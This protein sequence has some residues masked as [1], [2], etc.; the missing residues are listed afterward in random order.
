MMQE[1]AS[2]RHDQTYVIM[3]V[4]VCCQFVNTSKDDNQKFEAISLFLPELLGFVSLV[5]ENE[6]KSKVV[7]VWS[8]LE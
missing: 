6:R 7:K 8:L 3:S 4:M 5:A 1:H 2:I